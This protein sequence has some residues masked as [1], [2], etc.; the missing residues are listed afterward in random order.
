MTANLFTLNTL[1]TTTTL[2]FPSL[3]RQNPPTPLF[4]NG[5]VFFERPRTSRTFGNSVKLSG[6]IWPLRASIYNFFNFHQKS[7]S[8][9]LSNAVKYRLNLIEN[10]TRMRSCLSSSERELGTWKA[11]LLEEVRVL[12]THPRNVAIETILAWLYVL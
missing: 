8:C 6:T 5:F 12:L 11:T 9:L 7:R 3:P 4:S 10:C 1:F 2:N